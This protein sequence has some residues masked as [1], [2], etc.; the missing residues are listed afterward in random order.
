MRTKTIALIIG[1]RPNFM[2]IAPVMRALKKRRRL[3]PVL[4]H[5][6]QHYDPNMTDVFFNEL[7]ISRPDIYLGVGSGSQ[8]VQTALIM[9]GLEKVLIEKKADLV[10]VVGDV[11]S[12]IAASVVSAKLHIPVAH[13][14][15]GLRSYDRR[16][17]EEI[18]RIVTDV[19]SDYLFT[20]CKDAN[21]TLLKEGIGREK[22]YFV[23]NVMIDTLRFLEKKVRSNGCVK[24]MKLKPQAY[25]LVTLH[26]PSNV[27]NRDAFERI[28]SAF[29]TISRSDQ[30]IFPIH[31]RTLKQ[32]KQFGLYH[33][34]KK[35][36]IS[37]ID[38]LG[39]LDFMNLVVN[40]R[41]ILTDSGGIQEETTVLG[42]PCVTLRHNTE[43]PIT[44]TEGTNTLVGNDTK[45]IVK[46]F[47]LILKGTYKKGRIPELWD[48]NASERIVK[49]LN[50]KI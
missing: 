42:I 25:T 37:I 24:R 27:D 47:T 30:I 32:M 35:E 20:T 29:K 7:F 40:A 3:K 6:G 36:R 41:C 28:L 45:K 39:Y 21:R 8:A 17:P 5:T 31:P 11:N 16:M 2:K 15:A 49:I 4:I 1:A 22:I 46:T 14:E 33:L 13:V 26:R 48:G 12:T 23:G 18:N 19:L 10:M 34:I 50:E 43:R 38:P 9:T 44:I